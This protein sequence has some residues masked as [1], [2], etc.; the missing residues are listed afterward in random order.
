M[1][2]H[3]NQDSSCLP[4]LR[5]V[6]RAVLGTLALLLA[7][8]GSTRP[9]AVVSHAKV[10]SSDYL[11]LIERIHKDK[12][13]LSLDRDGLSRYFGSRVD[14]S[15]KPAGK[16][17]EKPKDEATEDCWDKRKLRMDVMLDEQQS[18]RTVRQ[19][20]MSGGGTIPDT[21]DNGLAQN[22]DPRDSPFD[23]LDR[24]SSFYFGLMAKHLRN[25][26]DARTFDAETY[27]RSPGQSLDSPE[28]RL[29]NALHASGYAEYLLFH[30]VNVDPGNDHDRMVGVRI[31]I[32]EADGNKADARKV[33]IMRLHPDR[34][35]DTEPVVFTDHL[36][37]LGG[38]KKKD[39]DVTAEAALRANSERSFT[40][41][42]GKCGS[43]VDAAKRIY[44][45]N[46]YPSNV[47]VS[48]RSWFSRFWR[49]MFWSPSKYTLES[50]LE[51]GGRDAV[52][53]LLVPKEIHSLTLKTW[54]VEG[55]IDEGSIKRHATK[56]SDTFTVTL[57]D[58]LRG[59]H[60]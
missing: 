22:V 35:Y 57:T 48:E 54:Y 18:N 6:V 42:I 4:R 43:Y 14:C 39:G 46:F 10:Y 27:F 3:A 58:N 1:F 56:P 2:E 20:V 30:Q 5:A 37:E 47:Y 55:A 38:Y 50:R 25:Y 17:K 12:E 16:S 60:R 31:Q 33:E 7:G 26:H 49:Q 32:T 41:R 59:E 8:C 19:N 45:W 44:G 40:H 36:L 9:S 15:E 24:A 52:V 34:T 29:D 23:R 53:S 51:A 28:Q 11:R 13:A 21:Q